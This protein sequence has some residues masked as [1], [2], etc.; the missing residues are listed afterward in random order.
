MVSYQHSIFR[1]SLAGIKPWE[2]A[3]TETM[4][5]TRM[6]S[7]AYRPTEFH[8]AATIKVNLHL[9]AALH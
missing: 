6:G 2:D 3:A 5:I 8:P 1:N 9:V 4:G 7:E